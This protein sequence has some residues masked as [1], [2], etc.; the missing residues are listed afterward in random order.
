LKNSPTNK[1]KDKENIRVEENDK[2]IYK[3]KLNNLKTVNSSID[4]M[5]NNW[6]KQRE[7][8]TNRVKEYNNCFSKKDILKE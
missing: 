7:N 8:L 3:E 1:F 4:K 5:M 2:D 6:Q